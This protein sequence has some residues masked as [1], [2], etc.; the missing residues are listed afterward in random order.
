M[1][2]TVTSSRRA[3]MPVLLLL[4]SK[5]SK[6]LPKINGMFDR[7]KLSR[8]AIRSKS[9]V[10]WRALH[11]KTLDL[12]DMSLGEGGPWSEEAFDGAASAGTVALVCPNALGHKSAQFVDESATHV[13]LDYLGAAWQY[14]HR[15]G[16]L[17]SD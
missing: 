7:S 14:T 4:C 10:L 5:Q 3:A 15:L 8:H 11:R 2:L 1:I 17:R 16:T 13:G 12:S 6:K 9:T